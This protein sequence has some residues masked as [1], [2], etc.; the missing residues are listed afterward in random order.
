MLFNPEEIK[1]KAKENW[2]LEWK[3]T[4]ELVKGKGKF[5]E[6]KKRGSEHLLWKYIF[7]IREVLLKMG[8]DEVVLNPIQ[9]DEEVK[10]QY[11]PEAGAILDRL[12]YLATIPRPDIGLSNEKKE[13]IRRRLP[14]FKKFRELQ[15]ILKEYKRNEIEGGEDF[16]ESLVSRLKIKTSDALYLI[17]TV[18]KEL[19][20]LKPEPTNFSLISH[21]TT[22]WFPLLA[23][24][25]DK[26]EHPIMLFSLVWR[27]RREQR[28]DKKHLRAHLNFSMVVMDEDFKI[29][30]G[31][32]L[33]EKFFKKLG[34]EH[35]KFKIKPNQPAYY[36]PGTNYEVFVKHK[37]I[38]WIEVS[39]IGMYSPVSLANYKIK[40]P[41]F[42]SGPGLGRIVMALENI[43]D[44]R[45]LY[46]PKKFEFSDLEIAAGIKIDKKPKTKEGKKIA[47]IIKLGIIENKD[48]IGIARKKIYD[49]DI[50]IYVSEPEEGKKLLGPGGL[51]EIYVYNGNILGVKSDDKKFEKIIKNGV[52]VCSFLDS[53]SNYFAYQIENGKKGRLTIRYADTLPSINL[54]LKNEILKYLLDNKKEIKIK[55]PIFVDIEVE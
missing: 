26:K 2:E 47:K 25:Q 22:A 3:E 14:N 34:F 23:E 36:A 44:I 31:K 19:I 42:N 16:T 40:Y 30:N 15:E 45:E 52:Y 29:E 43:K 50:K 8:F 9:L 35:V 11:G 6:I 46:Y 1:K 48:L 54:K 4:A 10:K 38:G 55:S 12:Y 32:E 51:N 18:F 27:F 20:E 49:K 17:N 7:R 33:T 24:L 28:E 53:I 5:T 37:K 41:V 39:E 13:L 21:A